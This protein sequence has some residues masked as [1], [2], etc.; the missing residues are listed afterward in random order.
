MA[1]GFL[2]LVIRTVEEPESWQVGRFLFTLAK[3][4]QKW[5]GG[6]PVTP[7]TDEIA[8]RLSAVA[9]SSPQEQLDQSS[10]YWPSGP[11]WY[12]VLYPTESAGILAPPIL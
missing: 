11:G 2:A 9:E 10:R 4:L 3:V 5:T 6:T 8:R 7:F 12:L 1:S